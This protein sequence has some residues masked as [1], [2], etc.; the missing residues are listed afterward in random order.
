ME[1]G[2]FKLSATQ[3]QKKA[4]SHCSLKS[5]RPIIILLISLVPAPISY[6][7]ASRRRRPVGYSFT[8]PL[9][10][11]HWIA[12]KIEYLLPN[13]TFDNYI[14]AESLYCTWNSM[15][16]GY[17]LDKSGTTVLKFISPAKAF[18]K[19]SLGQWQDT[20]ICGAV[21]SRAGCSLHL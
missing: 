1:H 7:L 10:P 6:S 9:P 17:V 20:A 18:K 15:M 4:T 2:C 11:K 12:C 5:S 14:I 3:S 8:Y 21:H 13:H 16:V 19:Y